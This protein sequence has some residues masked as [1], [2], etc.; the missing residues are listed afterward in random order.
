LKTLLKGILG[1]AAF[2]GRAICTP[3]VW[4]RHKTFSS[5]CPV[6]ESWP[7]SDLLTAKQMAREI[8]RRILISVRLLPVIG[9]H[10]L[11]HLK[12]HAS[13]PTFG[14]LSRSV[15]QRQSKHE[16]LEHMDS[17]SC[18][19]SDAKNPESSTSKNK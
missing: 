6:L 15:F 12:K 18:S 3:K 17:G 14:R 4:H 5:L 7:E 13:F 2:I 9:G 1:A 16:D 19:S 11:D 8:A 10:F